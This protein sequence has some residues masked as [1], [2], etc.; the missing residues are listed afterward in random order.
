S[1]GAPSPVCR[2]PSTDFLPMAIG[3]RLPSIAGGRWLCSCRPG[4]VKL[5]LGYSPIV[6]AVTVFAVDGRSARSGAAGIARAAT[7]T[8]GAGVEERY[9]LT[10]ALALATYLN[11]FIRHCRTV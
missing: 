9:T 5:L 10:D 11:G 8:A 3:T 4:A 2:T 6:S 7:R 1:R